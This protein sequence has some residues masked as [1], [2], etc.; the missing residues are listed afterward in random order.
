MVQNLGTPGS[1]QSTDKYSIHAQD[2][3]FV[4]PESDIRQ[5]VRHFLWHIMQAASA[6]IVAKQQR[7]AA[8]D[9][10]RWLTGRLLAWFGP[11]A[12]ATALLPS[13]DLHHS[14]HRSACMW[15]SPSTHPSVRQSARLSVFLKFCQEA[16]A[17]AIRPLAF[18]FRF[19]VVSALGLV[20]PIHE[21]GQVL[22]PLI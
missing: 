13:A 3:H 6:L 17:S 21:F 1:L 22:V 10:T 15:I 20:A 14:G 16:G 5:R 9:Q 18:S 8:E 19:V 2:P 7:D 4:A 12:A 11:R